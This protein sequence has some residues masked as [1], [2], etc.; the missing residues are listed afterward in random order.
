MR[1]IVGV[2]TQL[3]RFAVTAAAQTAEYGAQTTLRATRFVVGRALSGMPPS[4]VVDEALGQLRRTLGT[5]ATATAAQEPISA[6]LAEHLV[7]E[8][9]PRRNGRRTDVTLP[10]LMSALLD[11]SAD[12]DFHYEGHPAYFRLLNELAPD[13]ARILRLFATQGP[14]AAIDV[15][16]HRLFGVGSRLLAP[17]ITMIGAYAGLVEKDRVPAYLNNLNRL[18]LIWFSREMLPDEEAYHLLEAQP[19]VLEAFKGI[20][21]DIVARSIELTAFGKNLCALCGLMPVQEINTRASIGE[22]SRALPPPD[23]R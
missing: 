2:P 16:S 8:S 21:V 17:G 13:E 10:Q 7:H 18:G 15:R 20:K 6:P 22:V 4:S 11:A 23:A 19:E 1:S 9:A 5:T 3:A 14:Q 12:V